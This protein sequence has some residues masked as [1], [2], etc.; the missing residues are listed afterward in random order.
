M[1][2]KNSA[3]S[4]FTV[5]KKITT[6]VCISGTILVSNISLLSAFEAH[7][8]NV[9]A[10]ICN[11]SEIK[12]AGFWK[13]HGNLY[14]LPQT[15]GNETV[16]TALQA[17]NIFKA[18]ESHSLMGEKLKA[19]LLAMKFNIAY[20]GIGDYVVE[21][22]GKNLTQI[23]QAADFL[24]MDPNSTQEEM[25]AMKDLLDY[26]NNL[27]EI[28]HCRVNS[29]PPPSSSCPIPPK[30]GRTI[31]EFSGNSI[32]ADKGIDEAIEGPVAAEILKGFYDITLASF[33]NHHNKP[34]QI[35]PNESWYLILKDSGGDVV[36]H[37][38]AI[39]DLPQDVDFITEKVASNFLIG[40]ST[41]SA[42]AFHV[43]Y[44][45]KNPNSIVPLC[46]A[47]DRVGDPPPLDPCENADIVINV[48]MGVVGENCHW[49]GHIEDSLETYI[50]TSGNHKVYGVS[51][52]GNP[53][54]C[55]TN[56]E[57]Y[58][59]VNGAKGPVS[60]DDA[61][62]CTI[63]ERTEFLG[64]FPFAAG[65]QT[66]F[67]K[68][69]SK[70][71]P[72]GVPSP[73]S[74]G[75]SKLCIH[76]D[77]E[78]QLPTSGVVINEFLPNPAGSDKLP[79][80]DGEWVELYNSGNS[81]VDVAGWMLYDSN[82]S[83]ELLISTGNTD[84]GGTEVPAKG[85]LVVYRN[86]DPDFALNNKGGDTVRLYDGKIKDGGNLV[87]S[88]S[89]T[90]DAPTNKSFARIPD[91]SDNWVDPV[92]TPGGPNILEKENETF[93]LTLPDVPEPDEE[94]ET[95]DIASIGNDG[96]NQEIDD[97]EDD[98]MPKPSPDS[99]GLTT[100][101][102]KQNLVS[103]EE[104]ITT[105]QT[106]SD[107]E[108]Q[109]KDNKDKDILNETDFEDEKS[110][111]SGSD[112]QNVDNL[113]S[114]DSD[115]KDNTNNSNNEGN[116]ILIPK[117]I[118]NSD[119][120]AGSIDETFESKD[121]NKNT[122]TDTDMDMDMDIPGFDEMPF[123]KDEDKAESDEQFFLGDEKAVSSPEISQD[124]KTEGAEEAGI[125]PGDNFA[126]ES[127]SGNE[128]NE[129]DNK[130]KSSENSSNAESEVAVRVDSDELNMQT[131]DNVESD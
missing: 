80:P 127:A 99:G 83:H 130:N 45:D 36:A 69:A 42:T 60:E 107:E 106:E 23:A 100:S 116:N 115:N 79:K 120:P 38:P 7:V 2:I 31:I 119:E 129:N 50:P 105:D 24:L 91:G 20:F 86:E 101:D 62:P 18:G 8:V 96:R 49:S 75:V 94:S 22:E 46:A 10:K 114:D 110:N 44:S 131:V 37:T 74:V 95:A 9:T 39:G 40:E 6:V 123:S 1:P 92:P 48:N 55:Q 58:L 13:N 5:F 121:G 88:Y 54:Q 97:Q 66:I 109:N 56:E 19:Q 15:L 128:T 125:F 90:M 84:S 14:I 81:S 68:T 21:S 122:D 28:K 27:E 72:F 70:C 25:E 51:K 11:P 77:P 63:T 12:S 32:R 85:F 117:T 89:Y 126:S 108:E 104:K 52:R 43:A 47:L 78:G 82:D 113:L 33:D 73:G 103:S 30:E 93:N 35:Q 102:L 64:E 98:S 29:T 34:G 65:D 57:F 17:K 67:M 111:V 112:P 59:E 41:A 76:L 61:D 4:I 71:S 53:G 124:S 26:L 16:S 87:D 3:N 118:N